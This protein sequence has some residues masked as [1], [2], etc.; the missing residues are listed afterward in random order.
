MRN[1]TTI[2][3]IKQYIENLRFKLNCVLEIKLIKI[4]EPN[5]E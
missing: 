2:Y 3:E 1:K 5:I 4:L